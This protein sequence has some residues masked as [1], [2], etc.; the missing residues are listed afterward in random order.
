MVVMVGDP[1]CGG[2]GESHLTRA[3]HVSYVAIPHA[4]KISKMGVLLKPPSIYHFN[5][6]STVSCFSLALVIWSCSGM[7]HYEPSQHATQPNSLMS[8]IHYLR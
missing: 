2:A 8:S 6:L 3:M 5:T 1:P 7:R 4:T